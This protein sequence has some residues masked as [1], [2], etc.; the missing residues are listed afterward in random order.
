MDPKPT[1]TT[2]QTLIKALLC[3]GLLGIVTSPVQ[4]H[5]DAHDYPT[6]AR[7]DYVIGCMAANGE[8]YLTMQKCSCSI[9]TIAEM[10]PYS[11]YEEVETIMSMHDKRGELGVLFRSEHGMEEQ[12]DEFRNAQT[13]ADLQC[14]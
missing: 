12:L 9:D 1:T 6:E 7:V 4:A 8:D 10:V 5:E 2:R 3:I 13:E 11:E 14:F